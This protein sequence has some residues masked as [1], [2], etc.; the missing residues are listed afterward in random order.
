V[1]EGFKAVLTFSHFQESLIL[2]L[3]MTLDP[4]LSLV[5]NIERQITIT[6]NLTELDINFIRCGVYS[7]HQVQL[8]ALFFWS[9]HI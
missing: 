9:I 3:P 8:M 5:K 4:R 2:N 7:R 1:E 6:R